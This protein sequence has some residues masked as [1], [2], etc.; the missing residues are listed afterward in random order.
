MEKAEYI[1]TRPCQVN[2]GSEKKPYWFTL[3]LNQVWELD[4]DQGDANPH[5]EMVG[6]AKADLEH[7]QEKLLML[8]RVSEEEFIKH[9]KEKYGED[10]SKKRTRKTIIKAFVNA[11]DAFQ[12]MEIIKK[13]QA[14]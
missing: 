8:S 11:R 3:E 10:I 1:A 5:L 6:T 14:K 12:N 7:S 2:I 4:V 9:A 13:T